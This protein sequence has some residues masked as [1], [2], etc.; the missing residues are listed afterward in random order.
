MSFLTLLLL[1]HLLVAL[2][3]C[4]HILLTKTEHAAPAWL[5]LVLIS[6][7]LGAGLYWILGI[8]RVER[9]ARRYRGRKLR[10]VPQHK[11][12]ALP[13]ADMP[14]H[15]QRQLFAYESA[16][17]DAP[18]LGGNS[19]KPL[20]GAD[21]AFPEMLKAIDDAKHSIALSVYIFD[22][23]EV[24]CKFIAALKDAHARGVKVVV[25][26]DEIGMGSKKHAADADLAKDGIATARF[27]P[28][29]LKFLPVVN[30]RN[31]RKI[32]II[33]GEVGFIGGMNICLNYGE[34]TQQQDGG[35]AGSGGASAGS[36]SSGSSGSSG[37]LWRQRG[38]PRGRYRGAV[39][40]MHF[41]MTGPA[42]EQMNAIFE[43]DWKFATGESVVLPTPVVDQAAVT[44]PQY[45]RIVPDGPDNPFQ[46]TMWIMLGALALSQ[47]SVHI[48]T[49]YFLP[50]DVLS[51]A[52]AICALRG[53]D[54]RVVV[55]GSTDIKLVDWAMRA[56]FQ[57]LVEHGVKIYTGG[58]PFDHTKL[59]V[60][61][62][63]WVLAGSSNWDQRSLRLNFEA[64]FEC[65]D[66]GLATTLEAHFQAMQQQAEL[67]SLTALQAQPFHIRL[68]NNIARL[69]T[70]YL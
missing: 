41:R 19:V 58:K 55:P 56:K 54:V 28:Q 22:T 46:R 45:V 57:G 52:L 53:V 11:D 18:F 64:N 12:A 17:H 50:N 30:L 34:T 29:K 8:N 44:T 60:V 21:Q 70:P 42:L 59:M 1:L 37:R 40:D 10:H 4:V 32:M 26:V 33:D 27:I 43:E 20:I 36:G 9:R 69:F 7:F 13:F 5:A 31:H 2:P 15:H 25:L 49:P 48:L 35:V 14:T 63:A 66:A 24:G 3:V 65:Y 61:D 67:V 16:V 23:D 68:R 51:H 39:R 38:R 47:K 6:P 62:D